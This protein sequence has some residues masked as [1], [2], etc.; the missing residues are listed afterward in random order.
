M[1]FRVEVV[2][3]NEHADLLI[4][5]TQKTSVCVRSFKRSGSRSPEEAEVRTIRL[6]EFL[7]AHLGRSDRPSQ[8]LRTALEQL[9]GKVADACAVVACVEDVA[10]KVERRIQFSLDL[11]GPF[12]YD[13]SSRGEIRSHNTGHDRKLL[14]LRHLGNGLA[15]CR[16]QSRKMSTDRR[17]S[18]RIAN[19]GL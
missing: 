6:C 7:L 3:L 12:S 18:P 11:Y 2:V 4:E 19:L 8:M 9:F 5:S 17:A 14:L 10:Q 16:P 13:G 15:R 1:R